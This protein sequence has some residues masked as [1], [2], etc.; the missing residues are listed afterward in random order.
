VHEG[1]IRSVLEL[2]YGV[3]VEL[4]LELQSLEQYEDHVVAHI[5]KT[6][7]D[8]DVAVEE[9]IVSYLVGCDGSRST[10]FFFFVLRPVS[11]VL[12]SFLGIVRKQLGLTFLGET[13]VA[14]TILFGDIHVKGLDNTVCF[15]FFLE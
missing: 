3:S 5:A 2:D 1:I 15:S 6:G 10:S 8:G 12:L 9:A 11:I 7:P 13:P 14:R 4:G